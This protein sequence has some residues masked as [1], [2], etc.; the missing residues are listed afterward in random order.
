ML[1]NTISNFISILEHKM[2]TDYDKIIPKKIL[3]NL[4]EIQE[5]GIIKINMAKKLIDHRE[6]EFVK[7]GN[8]IHISRTEIIRYLINNTIPTYDI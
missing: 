3:F 1:R 6:L 8:K 4:K 7:I 5:L 2:K